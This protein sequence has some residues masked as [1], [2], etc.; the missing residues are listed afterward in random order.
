M[1][2]FRVNAMLQ[3]ANKKFRTIEYHVPARTAEECM[4][5][6]ISVWAGTCLKVTITVAPIDGK[7]A[8][9]FHLMNENKK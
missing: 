8:A 1:R 4:Q 7:G 6:E 5:E 2:V 3:F 9:A